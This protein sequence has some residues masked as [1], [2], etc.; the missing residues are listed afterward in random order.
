MQVW[1][2]YVPGIPCGFIWNDEFFRG[3]SHAQP[4]KVFR[5]VGQKQLSDLEVVF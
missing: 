2:G 3:D 1:I 4:G 5:S